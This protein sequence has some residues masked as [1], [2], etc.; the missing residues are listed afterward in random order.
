MAKYD[1]QASGKVPDRHYTFK[2]SRKEDR[3]ELIMPTFILQDYSPTNLMSLLVCSYL[4]IVNLQLNNNMQFSSWV[5]LLSSWYIVMRSKPSRVRII[6]ACKWNML[7]ILLLLIILSSW[8][9]YY[10]SS[11]FLEYKLNISYCQH[12][13]NCWLLN[14]I[15]YKGFRFV[16]NIFTYQILHV[17]LQRFIS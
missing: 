13:C 17:P 5:N 7:H 11:D 10:L 12:V 8:R 2:L 4:N 15:S 6:I 1:A 9:F 14:S 16:Q 3:I